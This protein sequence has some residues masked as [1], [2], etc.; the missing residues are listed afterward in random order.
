MK[1]SWYRKQRKK[2]E[3]IVERELIDRNDLNLRSDQPRL[4]RD[5]LQMLLSCSLLKEYNKKKISIHRD[6]IVF[7][8][9]AYVKD[10]DIIT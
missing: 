9:M 8:V 4:L 2:K 7:D 10:T 6:L 3:R 5:L 1:H